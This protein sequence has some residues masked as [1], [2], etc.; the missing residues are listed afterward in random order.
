ML[1]L[2]AFHIVF[3][4]TWFAGLFYLPRLFVY[5]AQHPE[6][7]VQRVLGVMQRKLLGITH[8]GGALAVGFG[9]ALIVA[10]P[11]WLQAGWLHAKLV[12]VAALVGYHLWCRH[13]V[14]Q[15]AAGR[16]RRSHVWYRWFNEV[17]ALLL[18]AIVLLAV[19]KPF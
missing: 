16:N 12:L 4:V 5:A 8:I 14:G 2:R 7:D 3:V 6:P 11:G 9:I 19:F 13:I 1:W 10:Q 18:I 17:P 15:F